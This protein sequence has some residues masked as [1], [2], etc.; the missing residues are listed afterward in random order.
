MA[1]AG[2]TQVT[3][4]QSSDKWVPVTLIH[5]PI[6]YLLSAMIS[7]AGHA[8]RLLLSAPPPALCAAHRPTPAEP[9]SPFQI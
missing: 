4:A 7:P 3:C 9:T 2:W 5:D 8:Q 6:T 1:H